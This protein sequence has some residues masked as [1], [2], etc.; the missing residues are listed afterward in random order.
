MVIHVTH[1]AFGFCI[2]IIRGQR[3]VVIKDIQEF[4]VYFPRPLS[5]MKLHLRLFECCCQTIFFLSELFPCVRFQIAL[6]IIEWNLK[7]PTAAIWDDRDVCHCFKDRFCFFVGNGHLDALLHVLQ[8]LCLLALQLFL[9]LF[10]KFIKFFLDNFGEIFYIL[11][12]I[13]S[14]NKQVLRFNKTK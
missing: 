11:L 12:Q 8:Q 2:I 5:L 10:I 1:Y 6:K 7:V 3:T 14:F 4:L 13:W 9:F